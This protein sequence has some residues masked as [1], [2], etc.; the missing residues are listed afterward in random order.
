MPLIPTKY[1]LRAKERALMMGILL[2]GLG[3]AE[4]KIVKAASPSLGDVGTAVAAAADGDTVAVPAGTASW[5]GTLIVTKGITIQGA[6]T[7]TGTRDDPT[8]T[9]A[10]IITDEIPRALREGSAAGRPKGEP[11]WARA[12][13]GSGLDDMPRGIRGRSAMAGPRGDLG[14]GRSRTPSALVRATVGLGKTFRLSGF[15]FRK[16]SLT[17]IAQNGGV[18]LEG[19]CQAARIDHCHFDGL[20]QNPNI[21]TSG[22]VYGVVDHCVLD[23]NVKGAESFSVQHDGWGGH[24]NGDGSWAD[25]SYFGTEKFLFIEDCT[26]NKTI[27]GGL[28][29][30][31]GGRYVAR[32]NRF[33][34][35]GTQAHGTETTGR[36][37]SARAIEVYNN[38]FNWTQA[39]AKAGELRGG[40]LL[41]HHNTWTGI[42]IAHGISLTCYREYYPFRFW[43]AANGANPLDSNDPHGVYLNGKAGTGSG[44]N[45]L[46]VP[47]ANWTPNQW[48]GYSAIN[49]TQIF[50]MGTGRDQHPSSC[51]VSNTADTINV[52][53]DAGVDGPP[54]NFADGDSFEIRRVLV[55]LDQPGRGKGDLLVGRAP[56]IN[57]AMRTVAWPRQV[58]DPVYSWENKR[59]DGSD[60][61]V[62]GQEPTIKEGRDFYNNTPKPGYK[63][64][65]YPHPLVSGTLPR[66]SAQVGAGN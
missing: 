8:L 13:G 42:R 47:G 56:I 11:G 7:V 4:G 32:Y 20:Y 6:T 2:T 28:D 15:T 60:V 39:P 31:G 16:G 48:T 50:P 5:T 9:D 27:G 43:G 61:N 41:V 37:R 29:C 57:E 49:M 36:H 58:L 1:L 52:K 3:Q 40:S 64:Y 55:A 34:N 53:S 38:T 26:F 10:T 25:D 63:P 21:G 12:G 59:S 66:G 35:L 19:T 23:L 46:V 65:P 44:N 62:A 17:T 45:T 22:Q 14:S 33:N 30:Y 24:Q 18:R 54:T 51:I